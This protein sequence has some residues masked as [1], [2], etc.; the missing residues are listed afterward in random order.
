[1]QLKSFVPEGLTR[2]MGYCERL[3]HINYPYRLG[4]QRRYRQA[5]EGTQ[6]D[7][8]PPEIQRNLKCVIDVGANIGQWST[9][10][11]LF[12]HT[13]QIIAFEPV[14]QTFQQLQRNAQPF[15]NIHCIQSAIGR[16]TGTVKMYVESKSE[17]SSP[18]L[19]TDDA[20]VI[21][22]TTVSPYEIE[23]PMTRLDDELDAFDEI[24]VL[25]I[26]V[27]GY[28]PQ[29][30]AGAQETLKRVQMIVIEVTYIPYY[31]GDMQFKDYMKLLLD[32]NQFRLWGLSCPHYT[33]DGR[34][35]WADAILI[36][37]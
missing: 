11:A 8:W 33:A 17:L 13:A 20:R 1:M 24:S 18:L 3:S 2:L 31:N 36:R 7:R 15:S 28:E 16:E 26:D 12:N 9:G 10:V 5:L 6:F 25:K 27:Q 4:L 23:V 19:L 14:P 34:P 22:K 32:D 29:V 30:I 35:A 21:H 37:N